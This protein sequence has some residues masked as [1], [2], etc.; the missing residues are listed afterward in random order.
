MWCRLRHLETTARP[1]YLANSNEYLVPEVRA[2]DRL[3]LPSALLFVSLVPN[4]C[5][6]FRS[7]I[8]VRRWGPPLPSVGGR[9]Y[10]VFPQTE[11]RSLSPVAD[12]ERQ[13]RG[14]QLMKN[15][16]PSTTHFVFDLLN[17]LI[18]WFSEVNTQRRYPCRLNPPRESFKVQNGQCV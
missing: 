17:Y 11:R 16:P 4:P 14:S 15:S 7:F 3:S 13:S 18:C 6:K 5:T 10:R 9:K 8:L 2:G 12:D 1:Q